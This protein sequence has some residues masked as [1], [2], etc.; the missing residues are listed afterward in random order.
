MASGHR[1]TRWGHW[2]E[3]TDVRV[4]RPRLGLGAVTAALLG[5]AWVLAGAGPAAAQALESAVNC[6]S[7]DDGSVSGTVADA[8]TGQPVDA[9][10]ALYEDGDP[11]E[12]TTTEDGDYGFEGLEQGTL[13][14][15]VQAIGYLPLEE[16]VSIDAGDRAELDLELGRDSGAWQ[17]LC[18]EADSGVFDDVAPD[19]AHGPAVDCAASW[20]L[21]RG[22][23]DDRFAPDRTLTRAQTASLLVR[24]IGL[25]GTGL[26]E[27]EGPAFDDIVGSE[28]E[29]TIS[30]LAG[31][32]IISGRTETEFAPNAPV[33]R[34][35]T[36]SLLART[37]AHVVGVPLPERTDGHTFD[38]TV[39][40]THEDAI[41][42]VA[43]AGL[44]T[45]VTADR[46]DPQRTTS[47]DQAATFVMGLLGRIA[48]EGHLDD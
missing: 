27:Y 46:F 39:G 33:T 8:A 18:D 42:A 7:T 34:A 40:S 10:V 19:A 41:N 48:E 1:V 35:Q 12:T 38:D 26:P 47:R 44:T 23:G 31:A 20:Q 29:E 3:R 36:A 2:M 9:E 32:G 30:L 4:S 22:V 14:V 6:A 13:V 24:V 21:I 5:L 11:V 16:Q 17:R 45:G 37:Y 28:H 43:A 25:A 15:S